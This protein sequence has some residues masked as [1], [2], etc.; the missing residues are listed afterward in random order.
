MS[1]SCFSTRLFDKG[2]GAILVDSEDPIEVDGVTEY[3]VRAG[4]QRIQV[5]LTSADQ[6]APITKDE[7][8]RV[9]AD[10]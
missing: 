5:Q 9:N 2:T 4:D 3:V 1:H 7:I 6:P 8:T 10:R